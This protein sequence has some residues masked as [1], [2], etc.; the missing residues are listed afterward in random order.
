MTKREPLKFPND[1]EAN[2]RALLATPP[3]PHGTAGS[4]KAAPPTPPKPKKA[5]RYKP[6]KAAP[7]GTYAYEAAP[8]TG[9]RAKKRKVAKKG[10]SA[11]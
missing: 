7:T 9:V 4:R 6:K 3:A 5:K 2:M 8:V 11:R 1:F 10:Q